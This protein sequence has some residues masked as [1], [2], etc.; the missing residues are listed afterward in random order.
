MSTPPSRITATLDLRAT[1]LL[2]CEGLAQSLLGG[3][4]T[5]VCQEYDSSRAASPPRRA[6]KLA[7]SALASRQ[8]AAALPFV[9][10]P[11]TLLEH[12]AK[13]GFDDATARD[14]VGQV[15][16]TYGLR[17]AG[18]AHADS[19]ACELLT[20][21]L[22]AVPHIGGG[23]R[24]IVPTTR[25]QESEPGAPSPREQIDA[26]NPPRENRAEVGRPPALSV[27]DSVNLDE[28]AS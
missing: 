22:S 3:D 28:V 24:S 11:E 2:A 25:Q 8:L 14:A 26:V 5:V 4:Y 7:A 6:L 23:I 1:A 15:T 27:L 17:S 10:T 12:M 9:L 21:H 13:L 16:V 18:E 19:F 20:S